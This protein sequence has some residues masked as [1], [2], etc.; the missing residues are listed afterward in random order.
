MYDVSLHELWDKCNAIL[1]AWILNTVFPSLIS[2]LIYASNAYKVWVDLR[3]RCDKVNAFRACYLHQKISTLVHGVSSVSVYLPRLCELWDEYETLDPPP[4]CRCPE[5]KQHAEYYQ[6]QKLY[7]FLSDPKEN[8]W[9][10]CSSVR[11]EI[12]ELV[13]LLSNREAS[14]GGYRPR[15]NYGKAPLFCEYCKFK[16]HTKDNCYKLNDYPT[17]FKCKKKGGGPNNNAN[18]VINTSSTPSVPDMQQNLSQS[19][20]QTAGNSPSTHL[21]SHAQFFTPEQYSQIL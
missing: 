16:G 7:Q 10:E 3:E 1:L 5:S 4:S 9:G 13:A 12:G 11:T 8:R 20:S 14:G 17:D 2:T 21:S 18:N 15:N 6:V 19:S